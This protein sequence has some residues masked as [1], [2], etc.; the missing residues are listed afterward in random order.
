MNSRF[1]TALA[2]AA[3]SAGASGLAVA[4]SMPSPPPLATPAPIITTM[5]PVTPPPMTPITPAPMPTP[6]QVPSSLPPAGPLGVPSP[7]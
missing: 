4:Q 3:L 7:H 5:A 1:L 2:A 6:A